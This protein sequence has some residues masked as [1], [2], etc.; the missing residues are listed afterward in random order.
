[1]YWN[2]PLIETKWPS[3]RDPIQESMHGGQHALFWNP[4]CRFDNVETN[5]RLADLCNWANEW[6]SQ[7]SVSEFAAEPN[8]HYDLANLVKLNMWIH[9][10]RQHGIIK[11]WMMLDQGDGTFLAGTGDS[12]LRCLERIPEITT[13]PAFISTRSDRAELY[14]DLEPVTSFDQFV[15][16]CRAEPNRLFSFRLTDAQAPYGIYWY[17]YNNSL[18]R[19]ITPG[20]TRAVAMAC[21]YLE[22]HAGLVIT[23]EWFDSKIDWSRYDPEPGVV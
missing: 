6:L 8:N 5:Q 1:M 11:P 17:E 10:I 19:A 12:R 16:L 9:S 3:D 4:R 15:A 14:R 7:V 13:V 20:T 22:Q 23:P 2:N 18:T 21:S